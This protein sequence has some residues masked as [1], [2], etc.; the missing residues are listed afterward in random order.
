MRIAFVSPLPPERTG[1][2]DY[3]YELLEELRHLVDVTAVVRDDLVGSD[4]A[5]EG[6][7]VIGLSSLDAAAFDCSVYQMGNNPKY[8]RFLFQRAL[9]EPGLLVLHDPSLADFYAE[10][11]G[12]AKSSVFREEIAYDSPDIGLDD[13]LPLVDVGNGR[14][15]LDRLRVLLA[16]RMI[17]ASLRTLVNSEAM[18][19]EM[20]RRYP[21]ADVQAIQLPAPVLSELADRS[22]PRRGEVVFGVFGGINYY[23]RVRPLVD[24]F[25]EVRREFPLARMVVAGRADELPLE[26][27]VRA[28]A[29][30]AE[31]GG[32]LEVRTNLTLPELEREMLQSDVGISL[33]WPTAGEMSAT[34]MRTLGAGRPAI[35]SDVRQ[36]QELDER[37]CWRVP[38]EFDREY[39]ALVSMM[40]SIALDPARCRIAGAEARR[41]VEREATYGVVARRY[42]EHVEECVLLKR[43]VNSSGRAPTPRQ[44]PVL[45]VNVVR[46]AVRGGEAFE[47][48]ERTIAALRSSG[49]DVVVFDLPPRDPLADE[50]NGIDDSELDD[51]L[52]DDDEEVGA[53]GARD[54]SACPRRQPRTLSTRGGSRV[55]TESEDEEALPRILRPTWPRRAARRAG[56]HLV[57]LVFCDPQQVQHVTHLARGRMDRG[58]RVVPYLAAHAAPLAPIYIELMRMAEEIWAPSNFA[59]DIVRMSAVTPAVL[60]PWPAAPAGR[61]DAGPD[62]SIGGRP[63]VFLSMVDCLGGLTWDNPFATIAAYRDAF[64]PSER[65]S[66]AQLVVAASHLASSPEGARRLREGVAAVSGTLVEEPDD[67]TARR[68]LEGCDV[69]VSLH[70]GTAFRPATGR[71]RRLRQ[72]RPSDRLRR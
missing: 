50:L 49:V 66:A 23:K 54:V 18:A 39:D 67:G 29:A 24:A 62:G 33:R 34:L 60:V 25:L 64:P 57:D 71:R 2:G 61:L 45:G 28:I 1:I 35:V 4:R 65:G 31:L 72:G 69:V 6:V 52:Y 22:P 40:R 26:R 16:R 17:A 43:Q 70:R 27:E 41:F 44:T 8:H 30:R 9:D 48:A 38:V 46:C 32:S 5:P 7:E 47:A 55:G 10:M 21:G 42:V 51:E 59:V 58:H 68:L 20:Q 12:H 56:P 37:F 63:C 14:K 19:H 3:G 13:E 36:F 15:D 53:D 11:C